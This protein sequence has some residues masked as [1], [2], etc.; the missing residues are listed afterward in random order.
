MNWYLDVLKKYA[1]FDGRA[2]RKEFWMFT[3]INMLISI[4]L[5]VVDGIIGTPIVGMVYSLGVLVPS[6][7][8]AIRRMHDIGKSGWFCLIPIYNIILAATEGQ[9]GTNQYGP[10]PK[11]P[12]MEVADHLVD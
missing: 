9:A 1:Q 10:D 11:N 8:V 4:A 7:A 2:R 12:E 5:G 3:L 6:I